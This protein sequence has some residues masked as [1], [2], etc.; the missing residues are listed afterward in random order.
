MKDAMG[1]GADGIGIKGNRA[2]P[3]A[4]HFT[5]LQKKREENEAFCL[6]PFSCRISTQLTG[7]GFS[8]GRKGG[9][10]RSV[11]ELCVLLE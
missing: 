3:N 11:C 1:E 5:N 8:S 7:S 2:I 4:L 6:F 10:S 9:G